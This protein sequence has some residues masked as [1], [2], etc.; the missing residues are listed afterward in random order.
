MRKEYKLDRELERFEQEV[1][2][3]THCK[4]MGVFNPCKTMSDIA[5]DGK[6]VSVYIE[7]GKIVCTKYRLMG[8]QIPKISREQMEVEL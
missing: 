4:Y 6:S 3:D 8:K 5:A 1:Y 2:I 7:D